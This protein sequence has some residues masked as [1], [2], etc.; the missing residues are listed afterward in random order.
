MLAFSS[1]PL[2]SLCLD[3][4][5]DRQRRRKQEEKELEQQTL[6]ERAQKHAAIDQWRNQIQ[7]EHLNQQQVLDGSSGSVGAVFR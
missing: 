4:L 1:P 6:F 7:Q 3:G 2:H 5:Q